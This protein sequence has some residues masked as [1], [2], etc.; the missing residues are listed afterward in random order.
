MYAGSMDHGLGGSDE[1]SADLIRENPFDPPDPWS[2]SLITEIQYATGIAMK[3][4]LL[5]CF[6]VMLV[7]LTIG[8]SAQRDARRFS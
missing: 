2:I 4:I 1:F 8:A 5:A 7:A 6:P 3:K